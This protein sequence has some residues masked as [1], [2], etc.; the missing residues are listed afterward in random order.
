MERNFLLILSQNDAKT[1][2]IF[3][4]VLAEEQKATRLEK[5][6]EGIYPP[7]IFG[8]GE[9]THLNVLC[10]MNTS[11]MVFWNRAEKHDEREQMHTFDGKFKWT[12]SLRI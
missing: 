8:I 3:E 10:C 4:H 9:T 7:F 2:V 6:R 1:S 11:L 5:L 12:C